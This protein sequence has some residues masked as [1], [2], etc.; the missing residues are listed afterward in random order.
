[1]DKLNLDVQAGE[2]FGHRSGPTARSK[3]TTAGM[4]TTQG[5]PDV[6]EKAF[7]AGVDVGASPPWPSS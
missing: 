3:T 7:L 6:E 2:I 5:R 1:M 4:L